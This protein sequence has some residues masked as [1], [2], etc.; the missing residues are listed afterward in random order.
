MIPRQ[1]YSI[2]NN[3]VF[4][5]SLPC[6]VILFAVLYDPHYGLDNDAFWTIW[7]ENDGLI[8]PILAAIVLAVTALSRTL[9][10]ICTQ[11]SRISERVFLEW[12]II[13]ILVT[14]LFGDLFMSLFLHRSFFELLL[15]AL[16]VGLSV[17][18]FPYAIYWCWI[19]MQGQRERMD[20]AQTTIETL[21]QGLQDV[22]DEVV[23]FFDEKNVAKLLVGL[24]KIYSVES[25]GNYVNIVYE[26]NGKILRFS[27]RNS[28]K[29]VEETCSQNGLVRCHRSY[30][31]NLRKI[32]LIRKDSTGAYAEMQHSGLSDIPISKLYAAEVAHLFST[33]I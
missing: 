13:E 30:Y 8:I 15:H 1:A 18:I 9:M 27:L 24:D 17:Q 21:R 12:Q 26:D 31:I 11:Q 7:K 2:K 16:M 10:I 32:K 5:L 33:R 20:E 3:I 23:Q 6:F 22:T 28:M 14:C 19:E 29:G 4:V 25:A